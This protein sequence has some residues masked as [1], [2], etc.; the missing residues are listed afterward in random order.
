MMQTLAEIPTYPCCH[1]K[2]NDP[3]FTISY[4]NVHAGEEVHVDVEP[5][6][7]FGSQHFEPS[8]SLP[9]IIIL[10]ATPLDFASMIL[11]RDG[12]ASRLMLS[13]G[14]LPATS[15]AM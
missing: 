14:Q 6:A 15:S 11:I 5:S 1:V 10:C 9:G 3:G 2:W 7:V 4:V 8:V 13:P 12:Q